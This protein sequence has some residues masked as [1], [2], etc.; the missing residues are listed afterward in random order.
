MTLLQLVDDVYMCLTKWRFYPT[1]CW[2]E[3][4]SKIQSAVWNNKT[5]NREPAGKRTSGVVFF[6]IQSRRVCVLHPVGHTSVCVSCVYGNN[7]VRL[8]VA[9]KRCFDST[10]VVLS[11]PSCPTCSRWLLLSLCELRQ[12]VWSVER[13]TIW[14]QAWA[15]GATEQVMLALT[16]DMRTGGDAQTVPP[17]VAQ[18]FSC[19]ASRCGAGSIP[20]WCSRKTWR[21][22]FIHLSCLGFS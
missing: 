15:L 14:E 5:E 2:S 20:G 11:H 18:G 21:Y 12:Q 6:G 7:S 4:D 3:I 1:S 22:I 16:R 19:F 17:P 8:D 13:D 10:Q 9:L